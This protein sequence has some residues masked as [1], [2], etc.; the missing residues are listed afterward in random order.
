MQNGGN[1]LAHRA[2]VESAIR[3]TIA[4]PSSSTA[5]D[6]QISAQVEQDVKDYIASI[7]RRGGL[8]IERTAGYY[9]F[10]H[11]SFQE[12]FAARHMLREIEYDRDK[13]IKEYVQLLRDN[14]NACREPF[15]LAVAFKSDGDGG[16]VATSMLRTLSNSRGK[17]ALRDVLLTAT[18][19]AESKYINLDYLNQIKEFNLMATDTA[20]RR[21]ILGVTAQTP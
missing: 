3:A 14:P 18:C 12:Y 2:E 20:R 1:N 11:R 10:I 5:S 9:G 4:A 17:N 19:I 21:N 8:F 15:I 7:S 16:P 13:K 6:T